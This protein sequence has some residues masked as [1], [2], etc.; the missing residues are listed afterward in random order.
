MPPVLGLSVWLIVLV[1]LVRYDSSRESSP[2]LVLWIPVIWLC[3][4]GSR[5]PSQWLGVTPASASVASMEGSGLDRAIFLALTGLALFIVAVRR[6][7]WFGL[8]SR[9]LAVTL[10]LLFALLSVSWSDYPFITFKRWIRDLGTYVMLALILSEPR[11]LN[12]I[13]TV[14][15]RVS[16]V[17]VI[18][19][20]ILIKYYPASGVL[21]DPWSGAPEY[22]GATTSKNMLGAACLISGLYFFSDTLSRWRER[23]VP[24]QRRPVYVNI[25]VLLLTFWLLNLSNSATSKACLV[26]GFALILLYRSGWA[27]TYPRMVTAAFPILLVTYGLV[28]SWFDL[29]GILAGFLGRDSTFHG[30]TGIWSALL[31]IQTH[32]LIGVGYQ[33]FWLGDRMAAVLSSLGTAWLNEAH[34]GY[35]EIYLSLGVIGVALVAG[36]VVSS[37]RTL[38]GRLAALP[39]FA[40][41]GLALCSIMLIYNLSESAFGGSLLWCVFLLCGLSVP[42][43][44][45]RSSVSDT[46]DIRH[47]GAVQPVATR[48]RATWQTNGI[49]AGGRDVPPPPTGG[50]RGQLA[51]DPRLGSRPSRSGRHLL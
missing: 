16:Y 48:R 7:D 19:S 28:D 30:R 11:K 40:S 6:L 50:S 41:F 38:I 45:A 23:R 9:N 46:E 44:E 33:S 47:A 17:L 37:Y 12:A 4:I 35:L 31:D 18:L 51:R 27:K 10:F 42:L 29:S 2:S 36:I 26:I 34:N 13:S 24:R 14:I 15:R 8:L 22:A 5:L 43:V 49:P 25:L 20:I 39:A 1:A 32:P 3:I 21:Y